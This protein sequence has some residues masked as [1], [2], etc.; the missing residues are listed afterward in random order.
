MASQIVNT[1]SDLNKYMDGYSKEVKS[2]IIVGMKKG[3]F[4]IILDYSYGKLKDITIGSSTGATFDHQKEILKKIIPNEIQEINKLKSL[5]VYGY[6]FIEN[7]LTC[8]EFTD[9]DIENNEIEYY[10]DKLEVM[11]AWGINPV[12]HQRIKLKDITSIINFNNIYKDRNIFIIPEKRNNINQI[13][14]DFPISLKL[15]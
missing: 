3:D 10:S 11:K 13:N 2:L 4:T 14:T 6:G 8:F 1:I 9:I 12:P 5:S 7:N 15:I